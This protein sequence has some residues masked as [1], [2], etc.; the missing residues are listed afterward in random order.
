MFRAVIPNILRM[1]WMGAGVIVFTTVAIGAPSP[2]QIEQ[3]ARDLSSDRFDVR[4][5]ASETLF[6]AGL[7][8]LPAL[9]QA[10]KDEDPEV[11]FRA[12]KILER[13][14]HGIFPDTPPEVA[15][16]AERYLQVE[17]TEKHTILTELSRKGGYGYVV[18]AKLA[19]E[20]QDGWLAGVIRQMLVE[21]SA[22]LSQTAAVLLQQDDRE[23]AERLLSIV[24]DAGNEIA[25]RA[26]AALMQDEGKLAAKCAQLQ[27]GL[28]RGDSD[29]M[30]V[31]R[32]L[33]FLYRAAGDLGRATAVAETAGDAGLLQAFAL[34]Q[35]DWKKLA[36]LLAAQRA[37]PVTEMRRLTLLA[38]AERFSGDTVAFEKTLSEIRTQYKTKNG[39]YWPVV[40]ALLLNDRVEEAVQLLVDQKRYTTAFEFYAFAGKFDE[41]LALLPRAKDDGN[42]DAPQLAALSARIQ[43]RLGNTTEA[44]ALLN[45]A[46]IDAMV[47]GTEATRFNALATIAG[48]EQELGRADPEFAGNAQVH[49]RGALK[50]AKPTDN[51]QRLFDSMYPGQGV[52]AGRW[53]DAL[54]PA[55]GSPGPVWAG[56]LQ[57]L[58]QIIGGQLNVEEWTSLAGKLDDVVANPNFSAV[59]MR[60][61]E[62]LIDALDAAGHTE[63][64]EQYFDRLREVFAWAHDVSRDLYIFVPQWQV[65]HKRWL[66]AAETCE[67]CT[68]KIGPA[69]DLLWLRG[70]ALHQ[71]GQE[72][73]GD[74][75][76]EQAKHR[77]LGDERSM[78]AL[79][80]MMAA[81]GDDK[82]ALIVHQN[83]ARLGAPRSLHYYESCRFNANKLADQNPGAAAVLWQT[84]SLVIPDLGANFQ[85]E[86]APLEIP[87]FA[88]FQQ[89][90][91]LY[92]NGRIPE[93]MQAFRAILAHAPTRIEFITEAVPELKTLG[94]EAAA[95]EL[96]DAV[97]KPLRALCNQYPKSSYLR[98][99]IAWLAVRCGYELEAALGYAERSVALQPRETNGI[100]TLAEIYFR[101]G[102]REK[103]VELMMQCE[104][105]EPN[106]PR[107]R[108]RREAF[109]KD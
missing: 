21:E 41:A 105:I 84:F 70:W 66:A 68:A 96:F 100:D 62:L 61:L 48:V 104:K 76:M 108:Q 32:K 43:W 28:D 46:A 72:K 3:S 98:N 8:A 45:S 58:N 9:R 27:A 12:E 29:V 44:K 31:R 71:A 81:Y 103:A 11:R 107:H 40:T 42:A 65:R 53:W 79:A 16:L 75:L 109:E 23:A 67:I 60:R 35:H 36:S 37:T 39:V 52:L 10:A 92:R 26:Y 93:A 64:S 14:A 73:S 25:I 57:T 15:E 30:N 4:E 1:A 102:N 74:A 20:E 90:R 47:D 83:I 78:A 91:A 55:P 97:Y 49:L 80:D 6:S 101:R 95:R 87:R 13:F 34:E 94:Q 2:A 59:R 19:E 63:L 85:R 18:L 82:D 69:P 89:A 88:Q 56:A 17:G 99:E 51:R 77:T 33:A 86:L 7:A 50:V 22:S 38:T 54:A 5:K 106:Q 24:A